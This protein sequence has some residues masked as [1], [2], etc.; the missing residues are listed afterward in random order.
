MDEFY[1][2][3]AKYNEC[4]DKVEFADKRYIVILK[5][6]QGLYF[7]LEYLSKVD[8]ILSDKIRVRIKEQESNE[9]KIL[10]FNENNQANVKMAFI[11]N[12]FEEITDIVPYL[13][14]IIK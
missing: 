13:K 6:E 14:Y 3:L 1:Q 2:V 4:I 9:D 12:S 8:I 11:G 5:S 7:K 10:I